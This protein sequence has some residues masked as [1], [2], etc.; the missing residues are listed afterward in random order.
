[1]TMERAN[2]V[3]IQGQLHT[4]IGPRLQPGERAPDFRAVRVSLQPVG[5]ND[6]KGEIKI[7]CVIPSIDTP[8]CATQAR[9]FSQEAAQI[10]GVKCYTVS[11]DLPF[12]LD[13]WCTLSKIDSFYMLSDYQEA[14]FGEAYGVLIKDLRLLSRSVF[15][16][17][18]DGVLCYAEYCEEVYEHVDYSKAFEAVRELAGD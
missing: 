7:F 15:V 10:E 4:L 13:R 14:S 5:L 8:I 12:A 2:A 6:L 1:M 11:M 9:R 17:D 18:R 3:K 16:I